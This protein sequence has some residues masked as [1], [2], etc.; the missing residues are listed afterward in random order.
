MATLV[1]L[2]AM[3]T[4][5]YDSGRVRVEQVDLLE[6]N[7]FFDD[8]GRPVFIQWIAYE[9]SGERHQVV[10][11]RLDRPEFT[12]EERRLVLTCDENG[13]QQIRALYWRETWSQVD[14]E[15]AEREILPTQSRRGLFG[16]K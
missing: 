15:I 8:K 6:K 5:P 11:W 10:G 1:L 4:V 16:V 2:L 9:W 12:F 13:A 3:A 14:P 7:H